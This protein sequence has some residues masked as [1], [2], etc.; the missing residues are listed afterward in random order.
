[1]NEEQYLAQFAGRLQDELN[2]ICREAEVMGDKLLEND[3]IDFKFEK[4]ASDYFACAVKEIPKYPE[5]S[6]AWAG[7]MGMAVAKLW[8]YDYQAFS[9]A[10]FKDFLGLRGFD[11]MDEHILSAIL[12]YGLDSV[13]AQKIN[14]LM[15]SLASMALGMIR[16]ENIEP[17]SPRA[18][19]VYAR[20]V[21]TI[22]RTAASI[23]L[24]ILGYKLERYDVQ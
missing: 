15:S 12:G 16:H 10:E 1:M 13:Q 20:A 3:D 5:V 17:Q 24:Y 22:Y 18:Y 2:A 9:K 6:L 14:N 11:D 19:Y 8:D 4:L 23:E 7:Y 21:Q